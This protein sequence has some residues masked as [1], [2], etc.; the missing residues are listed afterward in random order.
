M[1]TL[2]AYKSKRSYVFQ[3]HVWM[4]EHYPWPKEKYRE[5]RPRTPLPALLSG[6][7]AGGLWDSGDDAPRS[8]SEHWFNIV[9]PQSERRIIF[10]G[11]V[12]PA[13]YWEE[14]DVIFQHWQKL[15]TDAPERCIEIQASNTKN[16]G[17]PQTFDLWLWG[18]TRVLS[19][20]DEFSDS[21]VSRLLAPSPI[22]KAAVDR[23][24]YLFLPR[25][26]RPTHRAPRDP[27]ERMLAIHLRRGDFVTHCLSLANWNSTFYSWNLLPFLPD[28]FVHPSP[29][30]YEP[31]KN[32]PEAIAHY[33]KHCYPDQD[34]ILDKIHQSRE[35]YLR[36]AR[37]GE[38]RALDVIFLLTNDATEWIEELKTM[39]R[40]SGWHTVVATKD[41][42]LDQ[43][44]KDVNL[45]VDMD[46]GRKA[47][48]FIGN[49]VS[50]FFCVS[51]PPEYTPTDCRFPVV[52]VY[53]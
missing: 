6:P 53:E 7:S 31:G 42:E 52:L 14:G 29:E 21:P 22:V 11:D 30:G 13:I 35:D 10:T 36:A 24:E 9:C 16:D 49:G 20:W 15:L 1:N 19:L 46:F 44:Q 25:G 3:D 18:S 50:L 32:T 39:L 45:A 12:K 40:R 5:A 37:H 17:T 23:N 8:V 47:A 33:Q 28:K 26:P 43:E 27:Y 38:H 34:F 48:V 4:L 41:L 2:L 51:C